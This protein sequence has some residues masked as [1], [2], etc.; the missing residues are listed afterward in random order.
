MMNDENGVASASGTGPSAGYTFVF[1]FLFTGFLVLLTC[2]KMEYIYIIKN[3][4]TNSQYCCYIHG[5][6]LTRIFLTF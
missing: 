2:N 1:L 3:V 4:I 5:L 6:N